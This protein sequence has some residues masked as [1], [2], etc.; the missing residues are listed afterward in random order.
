MFEEQA[1]QFRGQGGQAGGGGQGQEKGEAE[2]FFGLL[3]ESGP[4]VP[5]R[6]A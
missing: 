6:M 2:R 3:A 5:G 1:D 4:V